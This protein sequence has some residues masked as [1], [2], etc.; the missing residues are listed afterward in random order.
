[1]LQ[2]FVFSKITNVSKWKFEY[3]AVEQ[4]RTLKCHGSNAWFNK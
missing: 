3:K 2:Y 1:M 4:L